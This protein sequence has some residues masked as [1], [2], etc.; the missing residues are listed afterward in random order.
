[1]L[2]QQL[3]EVNAVVFVVIVLTVIPVVI[4]QRL[5]RESGLLK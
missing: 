3:L 2:G 4:S 5:A 1:M